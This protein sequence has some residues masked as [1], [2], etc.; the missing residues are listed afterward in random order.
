MRCQ[1]AG[2]SRTVTPQR[3]SPPSRAAMQR[4]AIATALWHHV[5]IAEVGETRRADTG[6]F[7]LNP[8]RF[9]RLTQRF[10]QRLSRR[11]AVQGLGAASV[12]VGASIAAGGRVSADCADI[13]TCYGRGCPPE[14]TG[15]CGETII[16]PIPGGP[17][18]MCWSWDAFTCNPCSTTW[19]MLTAR[20]NTLPGCYGQCKPAA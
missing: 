16:A 18:G 10:G 17:A 4:V 11:R 2:V 1:G 19:E 8:E 20:C 5:P 15:F 9:D 14:N 3:T 7:Q 13:T 12:A 6:R